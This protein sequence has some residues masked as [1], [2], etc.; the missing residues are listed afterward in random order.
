MESLYY[1]MLTQL[2]DAEMKNI[3]VINILRSTNDRQCWKTMI[4]YVL[5]GYGHEEICYVGNNESGKGS[6][7]R[8]IDGAL[9]VTLDDRL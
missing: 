5:D 9:F 1:W 2:P 6:I 3:T 7:C 8:L 4:A